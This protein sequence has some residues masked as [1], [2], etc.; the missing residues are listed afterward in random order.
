METVGVES[1]GLME[2]TTISFNNG[3]NNARAQLV[4]LRFYRLS[5]QAVA[6]ADSSSCQ[7]M[8][9]GHRV[10]RFSRLKNDGFCPI[11]YLEC[12]TTINLSSKRRILPETQFNMI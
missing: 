1:V 3:A 10:R 9:T 4:L 12:H 5:F 6:G 8:D 7:N 2:P 11:N